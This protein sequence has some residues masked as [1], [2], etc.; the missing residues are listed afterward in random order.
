[1]SVTVRKDFLWKV[2]L[3]DAEPDVIHTIFVEQWQLESAVNAA[4]KM[5]E[6]GK[7]GAFIIAKTTYK[8]HWYSPPS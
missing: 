5:I 2:H 8:E 3:V 4:A 1:M 6:D 7:A